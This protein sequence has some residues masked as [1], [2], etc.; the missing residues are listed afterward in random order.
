MK[1]K[2]LPEQTAIHDAMTVLLK[3]LGPA[4]LAKFLAAR[5]AAGEDYLTERDRLFAGQTVASL[6]RK[7]RAFEKR[8]C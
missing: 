4:K 7:I 3:H 6:T 2:A 8:H 1:T 5:P